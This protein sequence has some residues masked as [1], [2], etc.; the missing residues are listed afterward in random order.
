[1]K[2]LSITYPDLENGCGCRVTL[3]VAGCSHHCLGCHNPE[4]WDYEAGKDFTT[5][6]Y[7]DLKEILKLP[8]IKGIPLSGGDPLYK[9]NI[10]GILTLCE[11]I[12]QDFPSKDIWLYTGYTWEQILKNPALKEV[13]NYI[14]VL[15]EG[16]FVQELRDISLAF[17]GS[18]NQ[19]IVDVKQ[20]LKENKFVIWA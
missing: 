5:K 19:R 11:K 2:Y 8:Y 14:D 20:S 15:V 12:R 7:Q 3:W 1:M 6:S 13:L 4:T 10:T 18:S 17:R 16:P 9:D